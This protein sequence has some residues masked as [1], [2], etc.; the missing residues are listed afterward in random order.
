M[1]GAAASVW[2]GEPTYFSRVGNFVIGVG[3][4]M[5]MR[6]ALREGINKHKDLV[7]S[8]PTIPRTNA[9]NSD[10]FNEIAFSIGDARLQLH[11]FFVVIYGSLVSSFGD[12]VINYV[13][14][15]W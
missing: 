8:S 9:L 13:L 3:V 12:L 11:G 6:Y 2:Y 15:K 14:G 1:A 7:K 5:S 10:F 4:W